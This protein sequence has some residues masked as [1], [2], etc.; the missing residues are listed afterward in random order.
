MVDDIRSSV[1]V[2]VM[3]DEVE[4]VVVVAAAILML[5]VEEVV[6]VGQPAPS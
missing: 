4:I 5:E 2:T 6:F 3:K 1:L